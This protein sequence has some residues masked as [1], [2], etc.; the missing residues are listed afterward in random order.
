MTVP[1]YA[2]S[3]EVI[4]SLAQQ[5]ADFGFAARSADPGFGVGD[6]RLPVN[7]TGFEQRQE[8]QLYGG[9]VAT[10]IGDQAGAANGLAVD[11][12]QTINRFRQQFRAG[13]R[14]PV[15]VFPLFSP[16]QPEIS[17]QINDFD[18]GF[19]QR[20]CALHGG[21]VGGGEKYHVAAFQHRIVRLN[22]RQ[23]YPP[24]QI[25]KQL[26]DLNALLAARGDNSQFH[27]RMRDQQPQ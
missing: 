25:G 2:V 11:F 12:G 20:R 7:D 14:H 22:E 27:R 18:T 6:Q 19:Q 10:G 23:I 5:N 8:P 17:G 1:R 24:A 26:A 16:P 4:A 13:V 3:L 15:P 9:W 21:A